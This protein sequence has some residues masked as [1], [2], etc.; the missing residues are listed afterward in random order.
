[1]TALM[2]FKEKIELTTDY[3]E[4]L[5]KVLENEDKD[6]DSVSISFIVTENSLIVEITGDDAKGILYTKTS[7]MDRF[8]LATQTIQMCLDADK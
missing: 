5:R 7:I 2:N 8:N 1:M 4:L 3:P 6:I